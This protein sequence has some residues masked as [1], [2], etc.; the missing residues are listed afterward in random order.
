MALIL[1]MDDDEAIRML[2]VAAVRADG[3]TVLEAENG[4]AG[5]DLVREHL[6]D[7]IISDIN[8]PE[9]DGLSMLKALRADPAIQATPV[10]LLTSLQEREHVRQGM[11][12][13]ADDY[14]TSSTTGQTP[15]APVRAGHGRRRGHRHRAA[16]TE[17][18]PDTA[19]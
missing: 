12:R 4:K 18:A 15:H 11:T 5:L 1:A 7:L 8:M 16:G 9:M 13:G 10:I 14:L 19:V 17:K 6:P 3:H 2:I